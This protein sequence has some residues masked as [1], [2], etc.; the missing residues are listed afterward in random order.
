MIWEVVKKSVEKVAS[1]PGA[2]KKRMRQRSSEFEID[3]PRRREPGGQ[4]E[5]GF[6]ECSGCG[7][8]WEP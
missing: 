5:G 2:M 4:I 7:C 6:E 8:G 3:I 1:V